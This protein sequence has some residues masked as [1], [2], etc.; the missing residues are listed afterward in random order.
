MAAPLEAPEAPAMPQPPA[1]LD[2][3]TTAPQLPAIPEAR[4]GR[5]QLVVISMGGPRKHAM[6]SCYERRFDFWDV[7][8]ARKAFGDATPDAVAGFDLTFV[9]GVLGEMACTRK[10]LE[11]HAGDVLDALGLDDAQRDVFAERAK[12]A[13]PPNRKVMG[14]LLAN[15]RAMRVAAASPTA[16]VLEDNARAAAAGAVDACAAA[17]AAGGDVDLLYFGHLAHDD[18]M[19]AVARAPRDAAGL[20]A[21]PEPREAPPAPKAAKP[22]KGKRVDAPAKN[23][24]LWG[25]FAYR[26][27]PKLYEAVLAHVREGFPGSLFHPRRRDCD[28]VPVDKLLQR[29]ARAHGCALRALAPPAFFRMPPALPSKIHK[30]WDAA[31]AASTSLQLSLYGRTWADVWLTGHERAIVDPPEE[32]SKEAVDDD[33]DVPPLSSPVSCVTC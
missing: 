13:R 15:L 19:D 26:A 4:D 31:F 28:V 20:A 33:E 25:T 22:K 12:L 24:E 18:T 27:S 9:P 29:V 10:R 21:L 17:L 14:C 8:V 6:L 32:E 11:A 5:V 1:P 7:K 30:K 23:H 2:D 16:V 3:A